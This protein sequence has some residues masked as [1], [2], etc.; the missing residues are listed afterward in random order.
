MMANYRK[1]G[2]L[3]SGG[4]APGMNAAIRAVTRTAIYHGL[5]V[6]GILHGYCGMISGSFNPMTAASVSGIIQRGGTILK[7]ARCDEFRTASG[8]EKAYRNLKDESVDAVI[9]IGG[10][11]TFRGGK[12]FNEEYDIPFIGIPGTIDN[13]ISGTDYT[14]GYDTAVNTVVEAVDKIRDTATSLDRIFFVEVMGAEAGYIALDAGIASGAEA[15]IIPE[16]TGEMDKLKQLIERG[17]IR[18]KS[19]N[20]IIVAEG[21]EEGG[22]FDIAQKFREVFPQFDVRVSVLGY[23]QRG[24]SPSAKDRINASRL[25]NAAVEALLSGQ[26]NVMAG[27]MNDQIVYVPFS[28]AEKKH[29]DMDQNLIRLAWILSS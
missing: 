20:I 22:A 7:T 9:V 16:I 14:I 2:V 23:L 1:I 5:E 24:G 28:K 29:K 12:S 18:E 26:K 6:T 17:K 25:G 10:D 21:D 3:T 19:S 4:D 27:L 8:R 13:D 11:G 15:I